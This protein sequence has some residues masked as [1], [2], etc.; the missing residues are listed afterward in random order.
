MEIILIKVNWIEVSLIGEFDGDGIDRGRFEVR[1]MEVS[2]IE[3][4]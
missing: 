2:L 4:S 3:V 1:L